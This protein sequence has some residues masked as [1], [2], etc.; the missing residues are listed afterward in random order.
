MKRAL[1]L[2]GLARFLELDIA[3]D[4]LVHGQAGLDFFDCGAVHVASIRAE[5][6]KDKITNKAPGT[7]NAVY[8]GDECVLS[9]LEEW[10]KVALA[11][12][13]LALEAVNAEQCHDGGGGTV[14]AL[15]D[16]TV[17]ETC[18]NLVIAD[19]A[20]KSEHDND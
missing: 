10:A 20:R 6:R 7:R 8:R 19:R 12:R 9:K 5:A 2:E 16:H 1:G 3:A 15:Y 11:V 13:R 17:L 4:D 14:I 18:S